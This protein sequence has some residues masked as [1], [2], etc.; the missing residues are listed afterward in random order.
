[1]TSTR[2]RDNRQTDWHR[3]THRQRTAKRKWRQYE[4]RLMCLLSFSTDDE[5]WTYPDTAMTARCSGWGRRKWRTGAWARTTWEA[6]GSLGC[7]SPRRHWD[8]SLFCFLFSAQASH[9]TQM[10]EAQWHYSHSCVRDS[11][12]TNKCVMRKGQ[13]CVADSTTT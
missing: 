12:T 4:L 7:Q 1:M 9:N 5:G 10:C 13:R 3:Q 6:A 8:T 2:E 11:V